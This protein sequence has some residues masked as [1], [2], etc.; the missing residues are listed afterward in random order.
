VTVPDRFAVDWAIALR[1]KTAGK[2]ARTRGCENFK[3]YLLGG[4]EYLNGELKSGSFSRKYQ[5]SRDSQ[6]ENSRGA[7]FTPPKRLAPPQTAH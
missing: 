6:D 3:A 1:E 2:D 7:A 4:W 5:I